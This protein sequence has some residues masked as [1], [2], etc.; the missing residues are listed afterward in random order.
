M[1]FEL[2]LPYKSRFWYHLGVP[3][4]ISDD[5]P[6]HFYMEVPPPGDGGRGTRRANTLTCSLEVT[7]QNTISVKFCVGNIRKQIP[8]IGLLSLTRAR[9]LC[10]LKIVIKW[11]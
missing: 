4:K 11:T 9:V 6:H 1:N 10:F 3:F 5:H 8:P 2:R 7:A